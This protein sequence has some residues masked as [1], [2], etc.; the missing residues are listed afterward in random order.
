MDAWWPKLIH[1]MFDPTLTLELY[2]Q[3]PLAFDDAPSSHWVRPT[4]RGGTATAA[5]C[6]Y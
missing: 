5:C 4:S 3:I 1:A 2:Q 6:S